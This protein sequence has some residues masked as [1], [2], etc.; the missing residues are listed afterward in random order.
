METNKGGKHEGRNIEEIKLQNSLLK[1]IFYL[2]VLTIAYFIIPIP[3]K[4]I[5]NVLKGN[6]SYKLIEI[7]IEQIIPIIAILLGTFFTLR[8]I[9]NKTLKDIGFK[10][11]LG[12]TKDFFIGF[13]GAFIVI[14][15][16]FLIE[17]VFGWINIEGYAW[18]FRETS[19]IVRLYYL[20]IINLMSVAIIEEVFIRGYILQSLEK[21]KGKI[22]A[23]IVSSIVFGLLHTFS[24]VGTWA[25]YVVPIS[26]TLAGILFS[27]LYYTKRNLWIP[28]VFHFSWNFFLY[29]FFGLTDQTKSY[30]IFI[31]T[32]ITGL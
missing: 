19:K 18:E 11:N 30:S 24:A 21:S 5:S 28:I 6:E 13:I 27:V 9:D 29:E 20:I 16:I 15:L 4:L 26:H 8:F 17:L 25:I 23:I 1:I 3:L 31:S 10:M 14:G 22:F 7:T 32:D 2:A 12:I